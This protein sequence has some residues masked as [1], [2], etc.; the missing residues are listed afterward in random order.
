MWIIYVELLC[1]PAWC[2]VCRA[3]F[4]PLFTLQWGVR[5]IL[6]NTVRMHMHTKVDVC[7]RVFCVCVCEGNSGRLLS[8]F[9][10]C[11]PAFQ[12]PCPPMILGQRGGGHGRIYQT[13][14][15]NSGHRCWLWLDIWLGEASGCSSMECLIWQLRVEVGVLWKLQEATWRWK[16]LANHVFN[17]QVTGWCI[18]GERKITLFLILFVG[19]ACCFSHWRSRDSRSQCH[20]S[21]AGA[22]CHFRKSR[23]ITS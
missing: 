15:I 23:T 3:P 18:L 19:T 20:H 11:P 17:Y 16:G 10:T 6:L 1:Q 14:K 12:S 2:S 4:L 7:V 22:A 13:C 5:S 8:C 21:T 9:Q